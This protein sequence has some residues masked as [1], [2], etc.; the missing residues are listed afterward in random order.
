[1]YNIFII[2][3]PKLVYILSNQHLINKKPSIIS[4]IPKIA[5]QNLN[6]TNI[7]KRIAPIAIN[8]IPI[9]RK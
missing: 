8:A 5:S 6:G 4:K 9:Y 1:M 3:P 7:I 2:S